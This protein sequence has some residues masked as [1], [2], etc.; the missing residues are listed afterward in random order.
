M[1]YPIT[2]SG[3][4]KVHFGELI[5]FTSSQ[6]DEAQKVY[7]LQEAAPFVA[8][9]TDSR[10]SFVQSV[11]VDPDGPGFI[12]CTREVSSGY[13]TNNRGKGKKFTKI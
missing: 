10:Q 7:F 8:K 9:N 5:L 1:L 13:Q 2:F 11:K 4:P 3:R 6:F 12:P